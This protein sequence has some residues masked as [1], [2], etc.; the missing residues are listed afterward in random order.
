M[1]FLPV[2]LDFVQLKFRQSIVPDQFPVAN[3]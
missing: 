1:F 2:F 3:A